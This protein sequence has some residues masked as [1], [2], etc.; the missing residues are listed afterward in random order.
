MAAG[1]ATTGYNGTITLTAPDAAI[2][3]KAGEDIT[4]SATATA[5]AG[6]TC[7]N[8]VTITLAV[9]GGGTP[10]GTTTIIFTAAELTA[11]ATKSTTIQ[12]AGT[13]ADITKIE[14]TAAVTVVP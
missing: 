3:V 11:G 7:A 2:Y 4:V 6:H 8:G 13:A 9:T 12:I 5:E 14:G 10:T 1:S